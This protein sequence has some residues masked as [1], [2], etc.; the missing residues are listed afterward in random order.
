MALSL[1]QFEHYRDRS[2]KTTEF[3]LKIVKSSLANRLE[4]DE[5]NY[6][7]FANI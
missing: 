2:F 4:G 6:L 7:R 1:A 5:E 3:L